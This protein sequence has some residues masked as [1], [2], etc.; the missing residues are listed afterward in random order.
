MAAKRK[1]VVGGVDYQL[2]GM[3]RFVQVRQAVVLASV[4]GSAVVGGMDYQLTGMVRF[5]QARHL[6]MSGALLAVLFGWPLSSLPSGQRG[7]TT[8]IQ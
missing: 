8:A 7:Q 5:V 3:V 4:F 6:S 1:G 2:T